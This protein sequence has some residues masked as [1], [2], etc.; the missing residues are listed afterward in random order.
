MT[1]P[2]DRRRAFLALALLATGAAA[3]AYQQ[4]WFRLFHGIFGATT[5]ATSTVLAVFL[6]GIGLGSLAIGRRIDQVRRPLAVFAAL[7]ATA[8]TWAA[9]TPWLAQA[10]EGLYRGSGGHDALGTTALRAGLTAAVILPATVAMGGSLPAAVRSLAGGDARHTGFGTLYA[11]NTAG[12]IVGTV[13]A[14]F[15]GFEHLGVRATLFAGVAVNLTAAGAAW[16]VSRSDPPA[17]PGAP[18]SAALG[19]GGWA[20]LAGA[21]GVGVAFL[22]MEL[23]WYRVLA[24]LTGGTTYTFALVLAVALGGMAI[25][26][27]AWGAG[28]RPRA[29]GLATLGATCAAE[30]AL[31][32]LP[33]ALGDD[34][35]L[36]AASL[37]GWNLIGIGG[38]M[39][40]WAVITSLLVL[41]PAIAAGY[42]YPL[43]LA[44]AGDDAGS[45]GRDAGRIGA[46]NT[47]GTMVGALAVGFVCIPT[48]G[49]VATWRAVVV[50]LVGIG[51][52]CAVADIGRR[53]WRR[54][55][56]LAIAI[57]GL[58][59]GLAGAPGPTAVW[60]HAGIGVGLWEPPDAD[61]NAVRRR[62]HE[63]NWGI[64]WERDGIETTVAVDRSDGTSFIVNGKSDGHSTGDA[65]TQVIAGLVGAMLHPAARR[66]FV[67][68]LGTGSTAGWLGQ[69]QSIERVDV[70]E[71]EPS[72][73]QFAREDALVNG[74]VFANPKVHVQIG[75]GRELLA[76][77]AAPYD[78]IVSEPS[79]PYRAGVA[80]LYTRDFYEIVR[81]QLEADGL[82]LQWVQAYDVDTDTLGSVYAT[83]GSVFP[84]IE[85]WELTQGY[86]LL[87]VASKQPIHHDLDRVRARM[88]E[89]PFYTAYARVLGVVG[90][91]AF[92]AGYL[93]GPPFAA[94]VAARHADAINTDDHPL[95]EFEFARGSVARGTDIAID[96]LFR[97]SIAAGTS[98]PPVAIDPGDVEEVRTL[99][100]VA[101]QSAISLRRPLSD[102]AMAR[103]R[104]RA[105]YAS[106]QLTDGLD[107]WP[108]GEHI[109]MGPLDL[110][111][112]GE[113][114]AR[115]GDPG[116]SAYATTLAEGYP[117][118]ASAIRAVLD[119]TTGDAA[120]ATARA[121]DAL[122]CYRTHPSSFPP[123]MRRTLDLATTRAEADPA[124]ARAV[125]DALAEPFAVHL[126]DGRR[127]ASRARLVERLGPSAVC[128]ALLAE[129][130]P[131][132]PWTREHLALR[133]R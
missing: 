70:A 35:A 3:L 128:P 118:E 7:E 133:V 107:G 38:L 51:V 13:A 40:A 34:V 120:V 122:I 65:P 99:A 88:R 78:V 98:G 27:A 81:D 125:F 114:R 93:A 26:S 116:S 96:R 21:A 106:E 87:L 45:L 119:D 95:M 71:L 52:A 11:A 25:G 97:E 100:A 15:Y 115:A 63:V 117:C 23:V 126:L 41:G 44:L 58:A 49:A 74:D 8:A 103:V 127:L 104:I 24:P 30:A 75:D 33:L 50:L 12:A 62:I 56:T 60:R 37:R 84:S 17:V 47:I 64:L 22:A 91:E 80:S 83:L 9:D 101:Q 76:T 48:W 68:G 46:F 121:V 19:S 111:L 2:P 10:A 66:A 32:A 4:V 105:A 39:A 54:E 61:P 82:F 102:E 79:N 132:Y 67:L 6:G 123:L 29:L 112:I 130:G 72:I 16:W 31:I 36:V 90:A 59:A 109:A 73:L 131:W 113:L 53:G 43:L 55:G 18:P 86:D 20:P 1:P 94:Q 14:C 110:I 57:A 28:L 89:Q 69:V 5:L 124:A 42:Q 108:D 129:S 92:Y 85:T 77:A